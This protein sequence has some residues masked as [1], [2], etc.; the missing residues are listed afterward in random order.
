ME[1]LV[2]DSMR[3]TVP[4]SGC[5]VTA[6]A[7]S[8][9]RARL[10]ESENVTVV[11]AAGRKPFGCTTA[12]RLKG[13]RDG[14]VQSEYGGCGDVSHYMKEVYRVWCVMSEYYP[15]NRCRIRNTGHYR[16]P[17]TRYAM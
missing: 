10:R 1:P 13:R 3:S 9:P 6:V 15:R 4:E 7:T 16:I 5:A 14:I 2:A 8:E 17:G 12:P 11:P